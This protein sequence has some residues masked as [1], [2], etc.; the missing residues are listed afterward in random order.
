M[1]TSAPGTADR[2]YGWRL[3]GE[4][5]HPLSAGEVFDA[6][7]TDIENGDIIAPESDVDYCE[8]PDLGEEPGKEGRTPDHHH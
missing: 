7:C 8:P 6:Y 5:L 2:V 4:G 3:R 1:R